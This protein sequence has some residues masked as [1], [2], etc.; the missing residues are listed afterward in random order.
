LVDL[1]P[2]RTFRCAC[3][4]T[5]SAA[6]AARNK[7]AAMGNPSSSAFLAKARYFRWPGFP[8]NASLDL[9]FCDMILLLCK[10]GIG[11]LL[12]FMR[13]AALLSSTNNKKAAIKS[14]MILAANL[15]FVVHSN[16]FPVTSRA[17]LNSDFLTDWK[18]GRKKLLCIF[19]CP[20][21]SCR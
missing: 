20:S 14:R 10:Y 17:L 5:V 7:R 11:W 8:A 6:A 9:Q 1:M 16:H 18:V 13:P 2:P 19:S 4:C 12:I 3:A 15:L 21:L